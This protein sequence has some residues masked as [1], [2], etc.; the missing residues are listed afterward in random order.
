VLEDLIHRQLLAEHAVEQVVQLA[1]EVAEAAP[2]V[3]HDAA[4][5]ER[6]AEVEAVAEA[7]QQVAEQP[8]A[9]RRRDV[10]ADLT[11]IDVQAEQ[12]EVDR[13]QL[14]VKDR[15]FLRL[16]RGVVSHA[17]QGGVGD[18]HV[19]ARGSPGEEQA[20]DEGPRLVHVEVIDGDRQVDGG[21]RDAVF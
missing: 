12:G 20:P 17:L 1:Q 4:E 9:L 8:P 11:G 10:E 3:V 5:V 15:A 13:R 2:D 14:Q 19:L 7:A 18:R 16:R 21:G 6:V